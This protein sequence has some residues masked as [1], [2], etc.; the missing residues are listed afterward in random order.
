MIQ[1]TTLKRNGLFATNPL[2][3]SLALFSISTFSIAQQQYINGNLST[4][5][6]SKNGTAAPAGYTWSELQNDAGVTTISNTNTGFGAAIAGDLS[7]ADDFTVPA[8][9]TWN[10]SKLTFYA[11]KTGAAAT[12]SP[13]NDLRVVI[14]NSNPASG[15]TAIVYGD[16]DVNIFGASSD[17]LMYR[18][19]NTLYPTP[20]TPGTSRKIWKIESAPITLSLPAGTYWVEFQIGDIA[21]T[22]NFT[23][24]STVVDARTQAGY[25]A[26][27][28]DPGTSAWVSLVDTGNPA[29]AP[30]VAVDIPFIVD[31]GTLGVDDLEAR[32][33]FAMYPNPSKGDLNL[34]W[35]NTLSDLQA[36]SL[37]IY[38]I[39]GVRVFS[40][41]ITGTDNASVDISSLTSGVYMLKLIDKSGESLTVKKLIKE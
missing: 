30:D 2:F 26:I 21:G 14:H 39:K 35:N 6:T 18:V 23:P 29:T 38:D 22:G 5:A 34:K 36:E 41:K 17:A 24:A 31:Y 27:Q 8:G 32:N 15:P 13:F 19:G 40:K 9:Q 4:G 16:L 37:E 11:Y 28:F 3:L 25:N 33:N 20:T 7:M 10:V 1:K 12:P